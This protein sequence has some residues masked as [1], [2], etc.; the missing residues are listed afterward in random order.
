VSSAAG[1][2]PAPPSRARRVG[3]LV[4]GLLIVAFLGAAVIGGWSNVSSYDWRF[5]VGFV[6]LAVACL[7]GSLASTGLGYV[8]ILE[9]LARRRLPRRR[10]LAVWS[11]SMLARYVP[12]NVMMVAG[13]VVLGREASVGGRITL[14]ASV[15]EHAILL[16]VCAT[17]SVGLLLHVG[18]L[19]QG[20]WLWAVAAVPLGM[21]LL[22][23][24][25]F[26]PMSAAVL[27]RVHREPLDTLLAPREVVSFVGLYVVACVLLGLGVWATVRGLVGPESGSAAV[28]GAGF[29]LSFVV[30]MLAFVFPSGLGIREG[31]FA[32]VLMRSLPDAV[33]IAAAGATR[34]VL[35]L[36]EVAFAG[37]AVAL[38]RRRVK[39]ARSGSTPTS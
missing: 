13:R 2:L 28:V 30:S 16:G 18:D 39:R 20:P 17:A 35:T 33:A 12:G 4:A 10:L 29:L 37:V 7:A 25:L 32:L 1:D 5:D 11:R 23:P 3:G 34:L 38:E 26:G 14:A 36:V 6:A 8:L 27:R 22:H 24:R 31:V 15:Y 19:G 21:A 9:R